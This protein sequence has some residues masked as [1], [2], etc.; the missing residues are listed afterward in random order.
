[1]IILSHYAKKSKCFSEKKRKNFL[2][3]GICIRDLKNNP[4]YSIINVNIYAEIKCC[5]NVNIDIERLLKG[6]FNSYGFYGG[7]F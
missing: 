6:V 7:I 5:I 2:T 4:F 1:M 3:T